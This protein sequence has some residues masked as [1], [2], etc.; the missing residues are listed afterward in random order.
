H[1]TGSVVAW[2][3]KENGISSDIRGSGQKLETVN[4]FKYL[5]A[6]VAGEGSKPEILS[7]MAQAT[8]ALTKLKTI[9]KNRNIEL[10]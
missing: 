4:K 9:W 1:C 3:Y 8:A 5:K 2:V 7:R 10:G 6:I